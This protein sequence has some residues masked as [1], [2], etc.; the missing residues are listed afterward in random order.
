MSR[1]GL[2]FMLAAGVATAGEYA[3]LGSGARL[4]VDR[5]EADGAKVRLYHAG[6]I[7][8]MDAVRVAGFEPA[9]DPTPALKAS[10]TPVEILAEAVPAI[11]KITTPFELADAAVPSSSMIIRLQLKT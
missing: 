3:V 2:V 5:H 7:V 4:H 10:A 6:G 9:E 8:E 1:L 11:S